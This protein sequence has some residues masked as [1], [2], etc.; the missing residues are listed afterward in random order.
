M[1]QKDEQEDNFEEDTQTKFS[2]SNVV[3]NLYSVSR[4]CLLFRPFPTTPTTFLYIRRKTNI[5]KE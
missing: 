1:R 5:V 3:R 4:R 2:L